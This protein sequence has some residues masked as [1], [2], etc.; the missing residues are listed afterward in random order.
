MVASSP[1]AGFRFIRRLNHDFP[2][3][4]GYPTTI[5]DAAGLRL[6]ILDITRN[7]RYW[8]RGDTRLLVDLYVAERIR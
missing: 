3:A 8:T 1:I 7:G 4:R 2:W 6:T 5:R